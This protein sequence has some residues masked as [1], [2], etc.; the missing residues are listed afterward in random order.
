MKWALAAMLAVC[1]SALDL[2]QK[3]KDEGCRVACVRSGY[4]TGHAKEDRCYCVDVKP[5]QQE[6][7]LPMGAR[8][9]KASE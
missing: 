1:I 4:D 2:E 3:V 8:R 9:K 6:K 5:Y 7:S